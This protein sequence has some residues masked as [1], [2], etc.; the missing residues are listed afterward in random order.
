MKVDHWL[1]MD[2]LAFIAE[3][4]MESNVYL[5]SNQELGWLGKKQH[6]AC[7]LSET[8]TWTVN[9]FWKRYMVVTDSTQIQWTEES[10]MKR[11]LTAI[12]KTLIIIHEKLKDLVSN[13]KG[14]HAGED[15]VC[16]GHEKG[17]ATRSLCQT[18][19]E[20]YRFQG[21]EECWLWGELTWVLSFPWTFCWFEAERQELCKQSWF[22]VL[23]NGK[24]ARRMTR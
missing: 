16:S 18:Y 21:T 5:V 15:R 11:E 13:M 1:L 9:I 23:S 8:F 19:S 12:F 4:E 10:E 6:Q 2:S 3:E 22:S 7:E 17:W 20:W 24:V 14:Y